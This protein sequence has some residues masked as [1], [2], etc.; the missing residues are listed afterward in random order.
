MMMRDHAINGF[1]QQWGVGEVR[2]CLGDATP[3]VSARAHRWI[4]AGAACLVLL[5]NGKSLASP[6]CP[7]EQETRQVPPD[8]ALCSTLEPIVRKPGA[9]PLDE[10]EAKLGDYLRNFC[11][12]DLSKGWK[13]D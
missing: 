2:R 3:R 9:L 4:A 1:R 12:R 6:T 5:A 13:V 11:H 8:S 10:Y 7:D